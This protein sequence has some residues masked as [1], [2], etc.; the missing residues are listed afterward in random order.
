MH[1]P[2]LPRCA[3]QFPG[4]VTF[5][6]LLE[7]RPAPAALGAGAA[8]VGQLLDGGGAALDLAVDGVVGD[9]SAVAHVHRPVG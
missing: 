9:R 3:D 5:E 1:P 7:L 4:Q 2:T 6:E 8:T